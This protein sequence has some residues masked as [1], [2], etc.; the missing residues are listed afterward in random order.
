MTAPALLAL[1][2]AAARAATDRLVLTLT[3]AHMQLIGLWQTRAHEALGYGTGVPGWTAYCAA[4]FGALLNVLP[5]PDQLGAMADAGIPQRAIAAPYGVSL[6]KVNGALK[7]RAGTTAAAP[8]LELSGAARVRLALAAAG[9]KGLTSPE[10]A[11]RA[12][13]SQ[14]AASGEL[15]RMAGTGAARQPTTLRGGYGVYTVPH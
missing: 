11:R 1:D 12:R 15:S 7:A 5:T 2:V 14:G 3:D 9:T 10:A 13:C 6:G 8:D 4:E